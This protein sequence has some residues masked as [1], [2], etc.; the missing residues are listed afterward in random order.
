M[1]T[2]A[3]FIRYRWLVCETHLWQG[4]LVF[5]LHY[6]LHYLLVSVEYIMTEIMSIHS[7]VPYTDLLCLTGYH[8]SSAVQEV[9]ILTIY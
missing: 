1:E 4:S 5:S 6:S 8:Y 3:V 2:I 9:E 7:F